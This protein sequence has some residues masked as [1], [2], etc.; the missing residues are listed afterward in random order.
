MYI[1]KGNIINPLRYK[2]KQGFE[3]FFNFVEDKTLV[4]E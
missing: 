4:S 1:V 2:I 3:R